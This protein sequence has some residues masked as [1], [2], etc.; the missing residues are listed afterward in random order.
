MI[1]NLHSYFV[2]FYIHMKGKALGVACSITFSYI[3]V[4]VYGINR[5][6]IL[7]TLF[8]NVPPSY[9]QALLQSLLIDSWRI[10]SPIE[11]LLL[12]MTA[13][14]MGITITLMGKTLS[15][16]RGKNGLRFSF[17]GSSM[18]TI[19]SAGCPGCGISLLSVL[20]I[21]IPLLP[22]QGISL[23]IVSVGLLTGSLIYL[24]YK[25][26]QPVSCV[27]PDKE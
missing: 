13:V 5:T 16:L 21:S 23:Q 9:K 3:I 24:L 22:F 6:I 25:L 1:E 2:T 8:G 15:S 7:N 10:F 27:V 14:L 18:L 4:S 19:M 26:Q 12:L 11:M 20:G 17:G